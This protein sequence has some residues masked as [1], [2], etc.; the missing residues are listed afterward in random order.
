MDEK[1]EIVRDEIL[2]Y[3]G[4]RL[5]VLFG[6]KA[7]GILLKRVLDTMSIDV[8]GF[9]DNDAEIQGTR[10]E[11]I[12]VY[13]LTQI[14]QAYPKAIIIKCSFFGPSLKCMQQQLSQNG[15]TDAIES[16][17]ILYA[18]KMGWKEPYEKGHLIEQCSQLLDAENPPFIR[19]IEFDITEVC[20]L[21]C[22][23]CVNLIPYFKA[24][25]HY[26]ADEIIASMKRLA[27]SVRGIGRLMLIGGETFLYPDLQKII[28]AIA[29]AE[30]VLLIHIVTNGTIV[31]EKEILNLLAQYGVHVAI[32][33]YGELSKK[34][35]FLIKALKV[36]GIIYEIR[37]QGKE[38]YSLGT[39]QKKNRSAQKNKAIFSE[40]RWAKNCLSVINGELRLCPHAN[41][42]T[43]LGLIP[44]NKMDY[45]DILDQSKSSNEIGEMINY[46]KNNTQYISA[47]DY[48]NGS[49]TE[50]VD[51]AV[52]LN[53][54]GEIE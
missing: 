13:S 48:C 52:Q 14:C 20:N 4:E 38:W 16:L 51:V 31:P 12:P 5:I 37:S 9:C 2:L 23:D 41:Y 30:N 7:A 39:P 1:Q 32:S 19:S 17:A 18:L 35:D 45:V 3:K 36:H 54:M 28:E 53:R 34:R 6:A 43:K 33:D 44:I 40:C 26:D 29:E 15:Y 8:A 46:L 11:G 25:K 42:G 47:C 50:V 24:P 10:V 27:A 21:K 22:R 49:N